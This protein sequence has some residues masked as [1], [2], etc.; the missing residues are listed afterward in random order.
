MNK[1]RKDLE[2]SCG[3]GQIVRID[4][5]PQIED[6]I[7]GYVVGV[8][9]LFLLL[10]SIDPNYINLNGYIVLR[11]QDVHRYRIRDDSEFFLNRAFHLKGIQPVPQSEINLSSFRELLD[12]A[13][14]LFPLV[15]IHRELMDAEICFIGCGQKLTDK[16]VTLKEINPAAKWEQT[17]RYNFKDITR[18]DFGGGYEEALALVAAHETI[19]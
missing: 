11:A 15:T 13:N 14:L 10:H 17:R 5:S 7:D 18:I 9:D 1:W 19:N 12:S 16:T 8:S 2:E 3:E 4:R 6:E